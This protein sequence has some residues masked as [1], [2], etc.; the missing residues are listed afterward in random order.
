MEN[1]V[2]ESSNLFE[3]SKQSFVTVGGISK[4]CIRLFPRNQKKVTSQDIFS[5]IVVE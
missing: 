2:F 4:N 1:Q 3:V 5:E